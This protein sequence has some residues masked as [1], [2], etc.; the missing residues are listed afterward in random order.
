M[1][2]GRARRGDPRS[3]EG[4]QGEGR[5]GRVQAANEG[6]EGDEELS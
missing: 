1:M 3:K 6:A 2:R 4:T 5:A